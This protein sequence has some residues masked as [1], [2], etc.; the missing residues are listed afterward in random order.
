MRNVPFFDYPRVYTD[1]RDN[2]IRIFDEVGSSL[3]R[4]WQI[5]LVHL[6][7]LASLTQQ[8]GWNWRGWRLA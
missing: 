2:L 4:L 5:S 8:M 3:K 6:M 1:H 7:Q